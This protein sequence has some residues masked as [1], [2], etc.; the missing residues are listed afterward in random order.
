MIFLNPECAEGRVNFELGV[1]PSR[2]SGVPPAPSHQASAT[3]E[4]YRSPGT[5][6]RP[7]LES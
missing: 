4:S 2:R 6:N 5:A 3:H 1:Q 7:G